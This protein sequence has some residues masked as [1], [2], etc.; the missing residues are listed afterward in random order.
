MIDC[1]AEAITIEERTSMVEAK[2]IAE[3]H[4][5]G[6]IIGGNINAYNVIHGSPVEV[7]RQ[8]VKKV[9]EE[10][11]DMIMPGCDYWLETPTEHIKAFVEA[12]IEY[13]T[14]S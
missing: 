7:I 3:E 9:V 4:N 2:K 1:G 13:G 6:Y 11:T 12:A 8:R 5:P 10:G 14:P